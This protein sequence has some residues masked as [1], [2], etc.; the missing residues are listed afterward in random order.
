MVSTWV[1]K[2]WGYDGHGLCDNYGFIPADTTV[3]VVK[4]EEVPAF[5]EM[6]DEMKLRLAIQIM[7]GEI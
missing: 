2:H 5:D 4:L 3:E 6:P 1:V 7:N